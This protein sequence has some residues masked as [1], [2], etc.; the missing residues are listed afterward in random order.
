MRKRLR[1]AVPS[2]R[3]QTSGQVFE[4]DRNVVVSLVQQTAMRLRQELV[5]LATGARPAY[6]HTPAVLSRAAEYLE[7]RRGLGLSNLTGKPPGSN[8]STELDRAL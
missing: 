2:S 3:K 7:G 6:R 1:R 8:P 5:S 4:P